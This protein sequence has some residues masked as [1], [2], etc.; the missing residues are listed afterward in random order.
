MRTMLSWVCGLS[1]ATNVSAMT[2]LEAY[3]Q[4]DFKQAAALLKA[5]PSLTATEEYYMGRMYLYGYGV[6][7]SNT[8]ANQFFKR[9]ADKGS[10][11]AQLLLA[12]IE[13]MQN[14]HPDQ[15]L[16][17]FKKAAKSNNLA[18]QMYCAGAYS[19]GV[20]TA[21][22]SDLARDYT[23]AA[24][25]NN[26]PI[27]QQMLAADFLNSKQPSTRKIGL[28]WLK[29]SADAEDPEAKLLLADLYLKGDLVSKNTELAGELLEEVASQ[30][31]IPSY[32]KM[33][34]FLLSQG[35]R[36]SAQMWYQKAA[37]RNYVPAQIAL[38]E[39][40]LDS[41]N[42]YF[43]AQKAFAWMEKAARNGSVSAQQAVAQMLQKGEG[44]PVNTA[45]AAEWE[46][47]AQ[48]P[49]ELSPAKVQEQLA[50]WLS[51][52]KTSRLSET[53]YQLP[54]IYS[55]WQ[56][57]N[58]LR[59]NIY[60]QA[61]LLNKVKLQD[62]YQEKFNMISPN[63]IPI[64]Y[65]YDAM[66]QMQTMPPIGKVILPVYTIQQKT[67]HFS[68]QLSLFQAKRE[69]YDYLNTMLDTD[70][71]NYSQVFKELLSQAI[72]GDSTAQFD[73]A[74]MYQQ[75]FGVAQSNEDALKFYLQAA[76]QNDLP[77]EYQLGLIYILGQGVTPDYKIGMDWLTDAAFKGN[78]YAQYALGRIYETG[79]EDSNGRQ[80]IAPD[81]DQ[82]LAMYQ[83]S[84]SNYYGPA[85]Y[86]LAE[87][88]VRQAPNDTSKAGLEGRYRQLKN[89]LQG[90]VDAGVEEAK[91][92]LAFY[93]ASDADETKQAQAFTD[94][95]YAANNNH[96]TEAAF[97]LALMY[98]RGIATAVDLKHA[99]YWY[100]KA[101]TNPVSAFIL[102]TYAAQGK[103]ITQND[104]KAAD[105]LQY[106]A[107]KQFPVANFNLAVLKRRQHQTFLPYLS[108]AAAL[109]PQ[110][111][112]VALA[113][114]YVLHQGTPDQL[115][116]AKTIY[117]KLAQ[118]GLPSAQIKLGY[119]YEQGLGVVRDYNQALLWYTKA[120][121]QKRDEA[122]F[123]IGRLYQFGWIG[124]AP[125]N[126][127]AKEW[128]AKVKG[129]YAPAAVAY[130][131]IDEI[132]NDDYS[133]AFNEY[134]Q[135]SDLGD[136]IAQY[137]LALIYEKGKNQAVD[138]DKAKDL[139]K[140][141]GKN[142]V[143]QA[144]VSLGNIYVLEQNVAKALPWLQS[145]VA[146]DDANAEFQMGWLIEKGLI[147]QTSMEQ[148]VKYYQKAADQGQIQAILALARLYQLG[149]GVKKDIEKSTAYYKQLAQQNYPEAQFQL[150]KFCLS[151]MLKNCTK[152]EAKTWLLQAEQNGYRDAGQ[153][154]RLLASQSQ[155]NVSY[156]ESIPM[157]QIE[158][159]TA[160]NLSA[161]VI[162]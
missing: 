73:V 118:Q 10:I 113:D 22:N 17:W 63:S 53:E 141:A 148:A 150:A 157:S 144:M 9:A 8:I 146:Q 127:T 112:G 116:Q 37:E 3:Y 136:P 95:M 32:Y 39:F 44:T 110:R 84:A 48:K 135:A 100:E 153:L 43:S 143:I 145:A 60:N 133:H 160:L 108:N 26:Q 2:G 27:A 123:L 154:L 40:Y 85:E 67:A 79:Y 36:N 87:I 156:V 55:V 104:Q 93:N 70:T 121:E 68:K 16:I 42:P 155:A 50:E 129:R 128:Y 61:P 47:K 35:D 19:Y 158:I 151:N 115:Q 14:N 25:K 149:I 38:A 161:K 65:Y 114:Y 124:N 15:A 142:H 58:A 137:N 103:G 46:Q 138:I 119:L 162:T 97:L 89:L 12:K 120:S 66:M 80:V 102:G 134:Q 71:A 13:L 11:P 72:L 86:R 106:A 105:Y 7:R 54:G 82:S 76:A 20:G 28:T 62:I 41:K 77:A 57:Q 111:A 51:R 18:A 21:K 132:E 83:L 64:N 49:Q 23:I 94:A 91:L 45:A 139:F 96:S 117:K 122:D 1:L 140:A 59:E 33:G 81:K 31:Y 147:P 88:M 78:A 6:L 107:N 90:A 99:I 92:P 24:A 69:G 4:G 159:G 130:G 29:K 125:N 5:K 131:F 152:Q 126:A 101:H 98:D 56:D 30:D 34:R 75:G 52:G 74:Q 109:D